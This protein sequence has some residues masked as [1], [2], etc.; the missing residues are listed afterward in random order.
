MTTAT[1]ITRP[2]SA[3]G[4]LSRTALV[5]LLLLAVL[6]ALGAGFSGTAGALGAL[7]GGGLV[8]VVFTFGTF[9]TNAVAQ[10]LPHFSLLIAMLTY[11]LQL[12]VVLVVMLALDRSGAVGDTLHRGWI[13]AGV[14]VLALGWTWVQLG[15]TLRLRVP[16]Y[17]LPEAGEKR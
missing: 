9:M 13:A 7:T 16:L 11:L 14:V 15:L 1:R 4:V 17:R 10:V 6:A 5:A 3:A 8:L 12:L 2:T